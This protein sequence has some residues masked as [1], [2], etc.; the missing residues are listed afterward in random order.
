[1][2]SSS[3]PGSRLISFDCFP[4]HFTSQHKLKVDVDLLKTVAGLEQSGTLFLEQIESL[5]NNIKTLDDALTSV[6]SRVASLEH[7]AHNHMTHPPPFLANATR[8]ELILAAS[9]V[10]LGV[11]AV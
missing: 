2:P 9:G 11:L 6:S 4:I 8:R 1:M 3:S 7:L 5:D 10:S